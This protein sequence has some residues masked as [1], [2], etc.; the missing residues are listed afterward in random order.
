MLPFLLQYRSL[1][2][3]KISLQIPSKCRLFLLLESSANLETL[4][5]PFP[6]ES[7]GG[8]TSGCMLGDDL[9]LRV[10]LCKCSLYDSP[11]GSTSLLTIYN[12]WMYLKRN[13]PK[14]EL[15]F[16]LVV[17]S[18]SFFNMG[19]GLTLVQLSVYNFTYKSL[20]ENFSVSVSR[21]EFPYSPALTKAKEKKSHF[22][23]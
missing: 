5:P 1:F 7:L 12:K 16:L 2:S 6:L 21:W 22:L 4:S 19:W 3:L 23:K 17:F 9:S 20:R 18:F 13:K 8:L 10:L 15:L 14:N 11:A